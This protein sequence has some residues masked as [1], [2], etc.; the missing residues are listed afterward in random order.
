MRQNLTVSLEKGLIR[1]LKVV[2]AQRE[3]SISGMI[4][5]EL[6]AIVDHDEQFRDARRRALA[7]LD[8][9]LHLG[10]APAPRDGL[11]ER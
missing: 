3:T 11:H 6:R 7:T 9:G 5:D 8:Q 2:A 10:G 4:S 1:R